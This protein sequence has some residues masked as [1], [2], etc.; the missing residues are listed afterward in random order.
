MKFFIWTP[1][2]YIDFL[3]FTPSYLC[4]LSYIRFHLWSFFSFPF[5]ICVYCLLSVFI[6]DPFPSPFLF[7]F[8]AFYPFSFAIL[9][10]L[11]FLICVYCLISVFICDPFSP[12]PFLFVFIAFYPFSFVILFLL[13]LSYLCL[14]PSIRFHLWSFFSFPYTENLFRCSPSFS[15]EG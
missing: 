13:P 6:C 5:L 11:P 8:I 14:L 7:V 10:L 15:L 1:T 4:S 3:P 2:F 12:F 9:F